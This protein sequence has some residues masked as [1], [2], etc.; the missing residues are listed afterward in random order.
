MGFFQV[1]RN[2]FRGTT[3]I[4]KENEGRNFNKKN[5][6]LTKSDK[7]MNAVAFYAG[8]FRC[9]PHRF[10]EEYMNVR[11]KLFQKIILFMMFDYHYILFWACRGLGKSWLTAVFCCAYAILYPSTQIVVVAGTKAQSIRIISEKV[12]QLY[13]NSTNLKREI[14]EIKSSFN[15]PRVDFHN[16]STIVVVAANENARSLRANIIVYDEFR[17]IDLEIIKNVIK[18]FKTAPRQPDYIHKKE[19]KH[20]LERNKEIF[21][22]SCWLKQHWSWDRF[23]AFY[24]AM[25]EGRQYFT[26]GLPYQVAIQEGLLEE[27]AVR[28]EMLEDDFDIVSFQI[29]MGCLPYGQA[30]NAFFKWE[31]LKKCRTMKSGLLPLSNEEFAANRKKQL[32][33]NSKQNGEVRLLA[34]DIALMGASGGND[35]TA[36]VLMRLIPDGDE[37]VRYVSYIET[38][39]GKHSDIQALRIKQLFYEFECDCCVIDTQGSGMSIFDCLCKLTIDYERGLEYQGWSTNNSDEMNERIYD[40]NCIPV[41]FSVKVV[42]AEMNH[43]IAMSLKHCVEKKKIR[44]LTSEIEAKEEMI[45]KQEFLNKS[46][47]EQRLILNPHM[48]TTMLINELLT[49]EGEVRGGYIKLVETGRRLKDRYSALA[50]GNYYAKLIESDLH[51]V[52]KRSNLEDWIMF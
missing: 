47:E 36:L 4:N 27:A 3:T 17:L 41:I 20:L 8:F 37:Y 19:Y 51:V 42:K 44:F 9:N 30:S 22:S 28:E 1:D 11:L 7:V 34:C 40:K 52:E 33:K 25:T 21:L 14:K 32:K 15:D 12:T 6:R 38:M 35:N 5:E 29:E 10:V 43:D 49:L 18:R 50:Y 45:N 46:A 39:T 2:K 31:D 23:L 26:C 48:Q 24:K 16:G 13:N